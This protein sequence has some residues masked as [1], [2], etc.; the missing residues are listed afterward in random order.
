MFPEV[1]MG[2]FSAVTTLCLRPK[3]ACRD[4]SPLPQ[5]NGV[6]LLMREGVGGKLY[7]FFFACPPWTTVLSFYNKD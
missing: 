4:V 3:F 1:E 5:V 7:F 2:H 6:G